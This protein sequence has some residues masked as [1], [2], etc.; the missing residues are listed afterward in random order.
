MYLSYVP[1]QKNN[2]SQKRRV[3]FWQGQKDLLALLRCPKLPAPWSGAQFR[4]L[5]HCR[6]AA[7]SAGRASAAML[8]IPPHRHLIESCFVRRARF[9]VQTHRRTVLQRLTI[10][11]IPLSRLLVNPFENDSAK[12]ALLV[13]YGSFGAYIELKCQ[14][15]RCRYGAC[16]EKGGSRLLRLCV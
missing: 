11:I 2:S 3:V 12:A 14:Q 16:S 6:L 8:P 1:N 15:R 9:G 7:S 10:R 5:R 4:P 13:I